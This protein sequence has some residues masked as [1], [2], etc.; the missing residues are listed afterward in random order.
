MPKL[1]NRHGLPRHAVVLLVA[2][3]AIF[4]LAYLLALCLR[5]D[6]AVPPEEWLPWFRT[7]PLLLLI[8]LLVFYRF[9]AF[10][11]WW[12][13]VSFT[14]LADLLKA[15][16]LSTIGLIALDYLLFAAADVPRSVLLL[17][18]GTTILVLG[19][20]RASFRLITEHAW[21]ARNSHNSR[22]ALVVGANREGDTIVREL[23]RNGHSRYRVAGFL[24][25]NPAIHGSRLGGVRVLGSP[26]DASELAARVDAELLFI[27][28]GSMP[29]ERV[30]Q[31]MELG[32]TA[33]LSVKIVP[34]V[35]D[36]ISGRYQLKIRD[37]QI[38]DLLHREPVALDTTTIEHVLRGRRVMV[39]GAGGSIGSEICRQVQKFHPDCLILVERFETALFSIHRELGQLE[40]GAQCLPCVAD[41]LDRRRIEKLFELHRPE[42]VFHAAAHKHVPMMEDNPGEAIQN[43]VFGT[44]RVADLSMRYGVDRFVLISTDKAVN[45]TSVMG[46]SKQLAE[47]YVHAMPSRSSTK[48]MVV[49]FGNVLG[50]N[51]SVVPIFQEQIRSGG[52]ITITHPDMCRYFMTIPEASELVLQAAAMGDGGEIFVL[53]MGQPVKILDLALDMI[54]LSGLSPEDIEIHY[55]GIRPGEK[56]F[57]ELR[58]DDEKLLPTSHPKV[59]VAYHRPYDV[60]SRSDMIRGLR[61]VL[62][63]KEL[64]QRIRQ[65]VP[66]YRA[67]IVEPA[68]SVTFAA[69]EQISTSNL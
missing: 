57:E 48:F 25:D 11:G 14:D 6:F 24:D 1:M 42:I 54:R 18:Y 28:A 17:D 21:P 51:G 40:S 31:L 4:V 67:D 41:I 22:S 46:A 50:S 69:P 8:K 66:E 38:N 45:P 44:K 12:R 26:D 35:E 52:P 23:N 3:A 29:G 62:H 64:L 34:R 39:T 10:H 61:S 19:G 5:F 68:T 2:H 13:Y 15:A 47:R 37:V 7:L 55:T 53:D 43:N 59:Q 30:R 60:N 36:I 20:V 33:N 56:L 65:L 16:T 49:R 63:S 27:I 58:F 9:G 32:R